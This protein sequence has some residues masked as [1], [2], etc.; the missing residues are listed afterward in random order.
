VYI[1]HG[2]V[3]PHYLQHLKDTFRGARVRF[4]RTREEANLVFEANKTPKPWLGQVVAF[5]Q[6]NQLRFAR[7][8]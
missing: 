5:L 6:E 1:N 4:V 2:G 3:D 7:S 8:L